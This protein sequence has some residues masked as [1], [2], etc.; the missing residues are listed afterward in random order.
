MSR[1]APRGP[2]LVIP[3]G[4]RYDPATSGA[5]GDRIADG[6]YER[7]EASFSGDGLTGRHSAGA[8]LEPH[9]IPRTGPGVEYGVSDAVIR[10]W[11]QGW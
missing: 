10:G 3:D 6:G 7:M 2:A 4:N 11:S 5:S 8:H 9:R 1:G